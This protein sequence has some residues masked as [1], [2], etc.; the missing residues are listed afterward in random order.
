MQIPQE[1]IE[2]VKEQTDIVDIIS[3]SVR[4]KRTG[5]NYI[6]L[7][8]FHSDKTPSFSVSQE[9]QIYKCFACGEAGNVLTFIMKQKNLTFVEAVKYLANKANIPINL[10]SNETPQFIK[11]REILY[12]INV[13]TGR[14]YFTNLQK[15]HLA[16]DY[17]LNRGI[18]EAT[19]KKFGLGYSKNSWRD[20]ITYLRTKG[21]KDDFLIEAGLVSKN[22]E[23][24]NI[25]DRFRNRVMFPVFDVKGR[26]IGFGGRVLDD[27]KPK[28]LNSPETTIFQKGI[29]LYGLNF[30]V[31]NKLK[32]DYM[33]IV[34]GYMD[35]ITLHQ[36]GVTNVVASLGTALTNNQA[37]LLKRYTNNVIISYD[38]DIA[39]Q[40]ATLRGLEILRNSGFEVKVLV[41]PQGKDPDEFVRSNGKDAFLKLAREALPLI[42]YRIK[43]IREGINLKDRNNLIRYGEKVAEILADLNPVEKDVYIKKIS[44]DTGIKEQALYDLLS[45]VMS[46]NQKE[47]NYVNKKEYFGTKLYIEP[48]YLKAERALLKLMLNEEIYDQIKDSMS[49]E[50]FILDSHKRIY[51][52]ILEAKNEN[53]NNVESYVENRCDEIESSK[54]WIEI[55]ELEILDLSNK[56]K[57]INDYLNEVKCFKLQLEINDLKNEQKRLE[58]KGMIEESI[59]LAVKLT[60]LEILKKRKRG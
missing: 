46:K 15:I 9:K 58:D 20:L 21:Y 6:G 55:K 31:K 48:A 1:I 33:I 43:R 36:Y 27:S 49:L 47:D 38:A 26:V 17:F 7:C 4:L 41:I 54:E 35:L 37:K 12:K 40:T 50:D 25:Y 44:E 39:G 51:S 57:L 45:Q 22:Q 16:K 11:K 2:K 13:E 30:A 28:Y 42:E 53:S 10:H 24:G 19:I 29:N 59:K 32:E 60:N 18:K 5:K 56:D 34:E 3:E 23:K 14:Y 8:P 52:L